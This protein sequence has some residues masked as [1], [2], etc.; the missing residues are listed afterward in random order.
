MPV[1]NLAAVANPADTWYVPLQQYFPDCAPI[2][3]FGGLPCFSL[4]ARFL[5]ISLDDNL[6]G[7]DAGEADFE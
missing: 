2:A 5:E 7:G 6:L 3:F 4:F 1:A